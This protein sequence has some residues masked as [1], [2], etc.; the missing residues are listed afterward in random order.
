MAKTNLPEKPQHLNST[1]LEKADSS[2]PKPTK[3]NGSLS[4]TKKLQKVFINKQGKVQIFPKFNVFAVVVVL[5]FVYLISNNTNTYAELIASSILSGNLIGWGLKEI[6]FRDNQFY[7]WFGLILLLAGL[8]GCFRIVS[9]FY[10]VV[11]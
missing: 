1:R 10:T 2:L 3:L 8:Y 4:L 5:S 9:T 7:A 11:V 6:Y